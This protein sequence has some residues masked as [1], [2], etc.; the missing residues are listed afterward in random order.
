M[1]LAKE[2]RILTKLLGYSNVLLLYYSEFKIEYDNIF[3]ELVNNKAN[4]LYNIKLKNIKLLEMD[5]AKENKNIK[6]LIYMYRTNYR[7]NSILTDVSQKNLEYLWIKNCDDLKYRYAEYADLIGSYKN[8]KY[9][10]IDYVSQKTCEIIK[11]CHTLKILS[12]DVEQYDDELCINNLC[13]IENIKCSELCINK[14]CLN[15]NNKR[16]LTSFMIEM[17]NM[18]IENKFLKK[19]IIKKTD[20]KF[21][22]NGGLLK[23]I[24]KSQLLYFQ[25]NNI[26]IYPKEM[27][28]FE[29]LFDINFLF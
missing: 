24:E 12:L 4:F 6:T 2:V 29:N 8:L 7:F 13:I 1:S 22:F 10:Y 15:Y 19:V 26:K 3:E 18:I 25:I 14:I 9:L 16:T 17:I 28:V 27:F 23:Q 20:F 21:I 11:N 5:D